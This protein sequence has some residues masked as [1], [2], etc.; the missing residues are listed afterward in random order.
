MVGSRAGW[1]LT[2]FHE[3]I[4]RLRSFG[5]SDPLET[6]VSNRYM[7][8]SANRLQGQMHPSSTEIASAVVPSKI[9]LHRVGPL[10]EMLSS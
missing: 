7:P 10:R 1:L 8:F 3:L 5:E 2:P 4:S 9:A 6:C